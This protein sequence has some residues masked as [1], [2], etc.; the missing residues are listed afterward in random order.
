MLPVVVGEAETK[1]QIILYS[2]AMVAD[3]LGSLVCA[4]G[5][6]RVYGLV[7][8]AF[9]IIFIAGNAWQLLPGTA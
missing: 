6:Q 8:V 4:R 9:G 5:N 3:V 1:R 7:A 2:V